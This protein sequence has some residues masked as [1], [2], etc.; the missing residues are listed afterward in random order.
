MQLAIRVQSIGLPIEKVIADINPL[1]NWALFFC[2]SGAS[3][4]EPGFAIA[5]GFVFIFERLE[6]CQA[7]FDPRRMRMLEAA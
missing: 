1:F 3:S 7:L 5:K 4:G 6:Q 2:E